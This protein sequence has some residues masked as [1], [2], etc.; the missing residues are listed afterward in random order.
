MAGRA[1]FRFDRQRGSHAVYYRERDGARIVV[2]MHAGRTIK[3]KTLAAILDDMG[4]TAQ[5]FRDLL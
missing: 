3:S 5:E 1:G 4:V 2:P